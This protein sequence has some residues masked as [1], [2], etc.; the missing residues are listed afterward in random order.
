MTILLRAPPNRESLRLYRDILRA[1]RRFNFPD[2]QGRPWG[3]VLAA[4][5]RAEFEAN[6]AA[7]PD[8]VPSLLIVGTDALMQ[9]TRRFE[10]AEARLSTAVDV[11]LASGA[12]P[13]RGGGGGG[14]APEAA[15]RRGGARKTLVFE[16]SPYAG[17]SREELRAAAGGGGGGE[18]L[19]PAARAALAEEAGRQA[20]APPQAPP[21]AAGAPPPGA[22]GGGEEVVVGTGRAR[23]V[24]EKRLK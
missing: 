24:F 8:A 12:G 15:A 13:G 2:A 17:S 18:P 19:G 20:R 23:E 7:P 4:S 6:R 1:A 21:S 16:S 22:A 11:A 5:A 10:V 3:T 9:I 14:G